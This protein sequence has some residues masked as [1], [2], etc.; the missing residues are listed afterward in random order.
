MDNTRN[1]GTNGVNK[2]KK[3]LVGSYVRRI[4]ASECTSTTAMRAGLKYEGH[5]HENAAKHMYTVNNLMI[6]LAENVTK[7]T[8][9]EMCRNIIPVMLK[10]RAR[11]EYVKLGGED[12]T[13]QRD[14]ISLFRTVSR[15]IKCEIDVG[16]ARK[17]T[18]KY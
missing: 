7:F 3:I 17:R 12:L 15:G 5:G 16:G 14:G 6:Y 1:Y 10:P 4:S 18:P 9:D 2:H 8:A 13:K 11:V